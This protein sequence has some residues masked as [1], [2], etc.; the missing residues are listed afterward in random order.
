MY[1][2][3]VKHFEHLLTHLHFK[4]FSSAERRLTPATCY[5]LCPKTQSSKAGR[6]LKV[7]K[8]RL[9]PSKSMFT[10][11]KG[12][13]MPTVIMPKE[14]AYSYN[15]AGLFSHAINSTSKLGH[16][17]LNKHRATGSAYSS[18]RYHQRVTCADM[19]RFSK[20]HVSLA[21]HQG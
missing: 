11:Y 3:R 13:K 15:P 2:D 10:V 5:V 9:P 12:E 7:G 19:T 18:V 16:T 6:P 17:R 4:T 21:G 14:N 1:A 20:P 8:P